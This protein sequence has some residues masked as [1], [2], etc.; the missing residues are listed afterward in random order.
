MDA[1]ATPR[2]PFERGRHLNP[3]FYIAISFSAMTSIFVLWLCISCAIAET[4]SYTEND[5][6]KPKVAG[7]S[8]VAMRERRSGWSPRRRGVLSISQELEVLAQMLQSRDESR[9][10]EEIRSRLRKLGKRDITS[11]H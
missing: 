7:E 6:T 1:F 8:A 4:R 10:E 11:G 2:R 9:Q 3:T 5:E